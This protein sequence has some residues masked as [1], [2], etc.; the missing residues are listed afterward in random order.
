MRL[1]LS[2]FPSR[3]CVAFA[4]CV[5]AAFSRGLLAAVLN[6]FFLPY[7]AERLPALLILGACAL[8][9]ACGLESMHFK[10]LSILNS[11]LFA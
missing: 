2:S 7:D 6:S 1:C 4:R 9:C 8:M 11:L 5:R 10:G 3:L